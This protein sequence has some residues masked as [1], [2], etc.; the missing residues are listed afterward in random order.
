[1]AHARVTLAKITPLEINDHFD[2]AATPGDTVAVLG[3]AWNSDDHTSY[4]EIGDS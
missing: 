4:I 1:M 3:L 2:V